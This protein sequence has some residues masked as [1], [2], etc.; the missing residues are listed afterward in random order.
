LQN[1]KYK[2]WKSINY[3][4]LKLH[5]SNSAFHLTEESRSVI[6]WDE[7]FPHLRWQVRFHFYKQRKHFIPV[8]PNLK[9]SHKLS[10]TGFPGEPPVSPILEACNSYSELLGFWTFSIVRYSKYSY[11]GTEHFGNWI[12]FRL[13]VRGGD[14][15]SVRSLRKM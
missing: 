6:E 8:F 9:Y 7:Y 10:Q 15:C 5:I 2:I 13:Q 4:K 1:H 3:S 14:T 12:C 11:W